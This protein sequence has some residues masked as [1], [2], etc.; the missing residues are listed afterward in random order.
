MPID[1]HPPN[2]ETPENWL[3]QFDSTP[4]LIPGC[5]PVSDRMV[6]VAVIDPGS[7][8]ETYALYVGDEAALVEISDPRNP[9]GLCRLFFTVPRAILQEP[10][11]CPGL[12]E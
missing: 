12:T 1:V 10:G 4:T 5:L 6:L 11:V 8:G 9:W 2:G 3:E 7:T